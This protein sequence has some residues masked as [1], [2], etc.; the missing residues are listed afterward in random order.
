MGGGGMKT[1]A[2]LMEKRRERVWRCP[3]CRR[4]FRNHVFSHA[5]PATGPMCNACCVELEWA[6]VEVEEPAAGPAP[7]FGEAYPG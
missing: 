7:K 2:G 3:S 4:T 6:E 5:T 1:G